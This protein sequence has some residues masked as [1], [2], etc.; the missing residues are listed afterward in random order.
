LQT[1]PFLLVPP[2]N[3]LAAPGQPAALSVTADGLAPLSY[4]WLFQGRALP[5]ATAPALAFPAV[6]SANGGAYS[7]VISNASG[8]VTSAVAVLT[9]GTATRPTVAITSPVNPFT[10]TAASLLVKGAA[11]GQAGVASV[12]LSLNG[13]PLG[14]AAG[15]NHWSAVV[16]LIPGANLLTATSFDARGLASLPAT[17]SI[18][19]LVTSPLTLLTSG[20]GQITGESS[21]A[22]LRVGQAYTVTATPTPS[23]G[24]LFSNW[25]GGEAPG[26]LA[27]LSQS[28]TLHFLMSSNLVLQ[29]SFAPNPFTNVAGTYHALFPASYTEVTATNAGALTATLNAARGA[30][31]A[32][33]LLGG[34]SYPLTGA[35]N[36]TGDATN[37][38]PRPGRSPLTVALHLDLG[39]NSPANPLTGSVSTPAWTS[40]L[41]GEKAVFNP[42]ANPATAYAGPY[43]LV[44]PPGPGGP[45]GYGAFTLANNLSG[46]ATLAG[47]LADGAALSQTAPLSAAGRLPLYVPLYAGQGA[48]WGWLNLQTNAA[49]PP[50]LTGTV[51]WIRPPGP[52]LYPGGFTVQTAILGSAYDPALILP[53]ATYTLTLAGGDLAAPLVYSNLAFLDGKFVNPNAPRALTL[54]LSPAHGALS[55]TFAP[56]GSATRL[57]AQGVLLQDSPTNAAGW[58]LTPAAAGSFLLQP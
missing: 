12:Q 34:A 32:R 23:S 13:H 37:V 48:L 9:V 3:T 46:L 10:T 22:L 38:L 44:I 56:P 45:V 58:F 29:A 51:S 54:T 42:Q 52:G 47:H 35:F 33:L 50:A 53:P 14:A 27:L 2:A 7:V 41:Y 5:G 28:P 8:S 20:P 57:T 49:A 18:L 55:V 1:A 40:A 25:L 15:S 21:G 36:L 4:Q 17:R 19:Y 39:A 24:C 30:Y 11:A 31:S 16:P 43:T 26:P 6:K